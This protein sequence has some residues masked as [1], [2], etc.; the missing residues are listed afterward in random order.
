MEEL[1]IYGENIDAIL[2]ALE[3]DNMVESDVQDAAENVS[4]MT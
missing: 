2:T 4:T 1:Y 3:E